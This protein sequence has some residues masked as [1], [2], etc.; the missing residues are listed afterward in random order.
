MLGISF[1]SVKAFCKTMCTRVRILQISCP[2]QQKENLVETC[3]GIQEQLYRDPEFLSKM[4]TGADKTWVCGCSQ[5]MQ[6]QSSH[7]KSPPTKGEKSLFIMNA[8]SKLTEFCFM[9][10]FHKVSL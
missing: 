6:Q 4:I 2:K 7:L 10:L 3:Q 5:A 9:N 8:A 1:E